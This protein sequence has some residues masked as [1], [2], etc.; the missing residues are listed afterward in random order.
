MPEILQDFNVL[1]ALAFQELDVANIQTDKCQE[2]NKQLE[3]FYAEQ[4]EAATAIATKVVTG[5]KSPHSID[6]F[7]VKSLFLFSFFLL[8]LWSNLNFT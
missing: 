5:G 7:M 4:S 3:I 8:L 2:I 6:Y 1:T